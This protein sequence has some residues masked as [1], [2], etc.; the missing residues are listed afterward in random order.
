VAEDLGSWQLLACCPAPRAV[1]SWSGGKPD[2][3]RMLST[4]N[5][6]RSALFRV[7]GNKLIGNIIDVVVLT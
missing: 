4:Y 1:I 7:S 5:D 3:K 2:L 6:C